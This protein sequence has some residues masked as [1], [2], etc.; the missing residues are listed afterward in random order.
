MAHPD[1]K[2]EAFVYAPTKQA[3]IAGAGKAWER[4]WQDYDFYAYCVVREVKEEEN[5]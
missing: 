4:R 5:K 1:Y 2:I 3:A